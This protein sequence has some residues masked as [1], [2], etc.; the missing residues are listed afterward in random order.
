MLSVALVMASFVAFVADESSS[1]TTLTPEVL[2]Q[3]ERIG[4]PV[5]SPLGQQVVAPVTTYDTEENTSSTRLWLFSVNGDVQRPLTQQGSSAGQAAFS[6]CGTKLAFV[7]RR[8]GDEAGQI[9][10]L[11]MDGPGEA[12][13]L[14]EVPTG[15]SALK[16]RGEHLYFISRVWPDKSWDEMAEAL[17]A[18]RNRKMT[19]RTWT[20]LPYSH[21]DHWVDE[22]RQAHLFRIAGQGGEIEAITLGS[23]LELS[24]SSTG[25]GSYD[26]APDGS[27][28]AF[29]ANS[30]P[31]PIAPNYDIF[32][33][34]PG[35]GAPRNLT[36][37][38]PAGDSSPLFSPCG[39]KLAWTAQAIRGFYG[40]TR[41]LIVHDLAAERSR[42]IT[43][44]WDRSADGLVWA[45]CS[46]FL[47]GSI[48]DAATRRI[49]RIP[50]DG[51]LPEPV[52]GSSSF[53]GLDV[54][55]D[56]TLVAGAQSFVHPMRLMVVDTDSGEA[57]RI[58]HLNDELLEGIEFGTFE[59]VTYAGANGAPIQMWVHYPPGFD[60][61]R[62]Y[63]LFLL[64]HGGPH[65]AMGDGFHYRWNAQT[66]ASWGY[67]TAWPNFHGS[68]GFGQDFVDSINPDWMTLPY[69][70]VVKAGEWFAQQ[71]WIDAERM[72]AG[73]AS[74]G[75]YLSSVLLGKPHPFQALVIH[76]PVYNMYS[77]MSA[78]FA[79]HSVRFGGY[80]EDPSIYQSI[81]PHYLAKDFQTP[82]LISHGQ[83]D[84]RVP[85]GQGFEIFRTLQTMGIE[86]RMIYFPDEN[87]WILKPQNSL[88]WYEQV[89]E[90]I[91]KFAPPDS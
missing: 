69:K 62:T 8:D 6:P 70:D 12:E 60:A 59:S 87:H 81:S 7:T 72:V 26:A 25:A 45:P 11:P 42:S 56:G 9:Y 44:D 50:L 61:S 20:A 86:S 23:G 71:P 64:I 30:I 90:W 13:R 15:V 33:V 29:V 28:V 54:S 14:S 41:R 68:S 80:W 58:D 88:Y 43:H 76:A 91:A 66:F 82:A 39:Q 24:R 18:Q 40:D 74:Y 27:I 47:Y 22:A 34:E 63:P 55:A 84:Y 49:Y 89:R 4:S 3:I 46:T 57:R 65:G 75:G 5:I 35:S 31:D 17:K 10:L 67:V 1:P 32:V 19:A 38:N 85:V 77:Q 36:A 73:G 16:W 53:S 48:D 79:V 2:W 51:S 21:F 78:D 37:D 52:T 83:L